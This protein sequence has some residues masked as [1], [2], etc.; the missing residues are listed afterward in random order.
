MVLKILWK[1][2]ALLA[3]LYFFVFG[4]SLMG[5]SFKVLGAEASGDIFGFVNN[6][7]AGFLFYFFTKR[8]K[9]RRREIRKSI[10]PPGAEGKEEKGALG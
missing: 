9:R 6:A 8:K 7:V 10:P 2:F 4:L 1:V 5:S 3:L